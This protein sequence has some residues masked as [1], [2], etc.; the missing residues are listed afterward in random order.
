VSQPHQ[1]TVRNRLLK[2]LSQDDFALLQP[3]LEPI[4][5]ELKQTLITPNQPVK[6]LFFPEG[7]TARSRP[8]PQRA[9]R[10]RRR[11]SAERA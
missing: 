11:S 2:A 9:A 7:G 1:N 6:R 5:A 10:S 8:R 4:R 3:N